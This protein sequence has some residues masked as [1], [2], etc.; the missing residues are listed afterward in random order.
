M[1]KNRS[2][3][4]LTGDTKLAF[5]KLLSR[6]QQLHM[7]DKL[8]AL[9]LLNNLNQKTGTTCVSQAT[10]VGDTGLCDRTIRNSVPRLERQ[11]WFEVQR[12]FMKFHTY[13]PAWFRLTEGLPDLAA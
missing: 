7:P 13:R 1:Q 5:L 10:I 9:A 11:G 6:D 3:L 8:I 4:W 2:A 12:D